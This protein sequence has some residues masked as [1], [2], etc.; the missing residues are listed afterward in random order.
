MHLLNTST[1]KTQ[2]F[3][4]GKIP[5]YV[6]LSH[7]WEDEEISYKDLTEPR[8][9]PS[10]LKG[11]IKLSSFCS[12]ARQ[13]GWEWVWM[14]TCC[15][16]KNSSAELSEAINS[17]YQW[18]RQAGYCIA[19]L[20][21]I[22]IAKAEPMI[23]RKRFWKSEW[24]ERG[25]ALQELLASREVVFYDRS[26]NAIGTRTRLEAY[27][28]R[29]THI[30]TDHL[31]KPLYASAAAKMSWASNRKTSRPED[32][33]Y[34][35]LGL[36]DV[37]MPLLYGEGEFKAFQRLQYEIIRSRRD[38]SIF[39]WSSPASSNVEKK[40]SDYFLALAPRPTLLAPSPKYFSESGDIISI[41]LLHYWN[42]YAPPILYDGLVWTLERSF[43]EDKDQKESELLAP[44]EVLYIAPLACAKASNMLPVK[45]QMVMSH[46]S[47]PRRGPCT[48]LGS[49][50]E[51]EMQKIGESEAKEYRL[52]QE[53]PRARESWHKWIFR[54]GFTLRLSKSAQHQCSR[55]TVSG[56][57]V[58]LRTTS[59]PDTYIVSTRERLQ[60]RAGI[61]MQHKK[62]AVVE[63]S[64]DPH[65]YSNN[66]RLVMKVNTQSF[67]QSFKV[68][69]GGPSELSEHNFISLGDR[70]TVLLD[71]GQNISFSP[72]HEQR[73][74]ESEV[75]V[76]IDC[77]IIDLQGLSEIFSDDQTGEPSDDADD[78]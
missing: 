38:E 3:S 62:G 69:F 12:L 6:I 30:S 52:V 1:R 71:H 15:I 44:D 70:A 7:R 66:R 35:L 65:N 24:F 22:S 51:N 21:D 43:M 33:A 16:D 25:W 50:S 36:F 26:W 9:D 57:G 60:T 31:S 42:L 76:Y 28:S 78:L 49:F 17:M 54:R 10:T 40:Y 67:K 23:E 29:A 27:V 72:K 2:D 41:S 14:D 68:D 74:G 4:P 18:Y 46:H 32:I 64:C 48:N 8:R 56:P 59:E 34:S 37:N 11:W 77:D 58:E 45:L 61:V 75:V 47:P 5:P 13:D 19:Y 73:M 53:Q 20:A 39:A 55:P 63:V